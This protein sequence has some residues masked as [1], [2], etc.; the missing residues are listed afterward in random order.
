LFIEKLNFQLDSSI[1]K[2]SNTLLKRKLS[3]NQSL[4]S[5][6]VIDVELGREDYG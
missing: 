5:S 3:H 4:F 2:Y 1:I 6:V